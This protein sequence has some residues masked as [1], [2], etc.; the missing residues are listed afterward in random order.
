MTRTGAK[1]GRSASS[2]LEI[3]AA[4][5]QAQH[6]PAATASK[7]AGRRAEASGWAG[8]GAGMCETGRDIALNIGRLVAAR[9]EIHPEIRSAAI[10]RERIEAQRNILLAADIAQDGQSNHIAR[11]VGSKTVA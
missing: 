1:N 11:M 2:S 8:S 6:K 5:A 3:S 9:G 4:S 10:A 7:S